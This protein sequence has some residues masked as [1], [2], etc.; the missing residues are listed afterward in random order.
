[1]IL[2][3]HPTGNAN[4]RH[5][6]LGLFRAGLT[7]EFWTC[8]HYRAPALLERLLPARVAGQLRRRAW[9]PEL[10]DAIRT[11][12]FREL[13]RHVAPRLGLAGLTAHET[14]VFSVDA[15]YRA[16]DRAVARR[17]GRGG[18]RAVY[19]YEDGA[20]S[21]FME[22]RRRGL[23]TLYDL[24]IGHWRAARALLLEEA[25]REPEWAATL[26]GN[27]D[28]AAKTE[29]K[30]AEL[31]LADVV[32]VA[33]SYTRRTLD[34]AADFRGAVLVVPYGAPALASVPSSLPLPPAKTLRVL[35]VGS[36]GQRKGLSYLFA[37]CRR[38]RSAVT[39]TVIGR[40]PAEPCAALD[41]ELRSVRWIPSCPH[42]QVLA[43]MAAHDVFVFPSLFEGFGLVLLEALA[44][45]LPVITTPHTAGPDLIRDGV[46]GFIVPIRDSSAIA[47]R[48][49]LLH[50]EPERRAGM[51]RSARLRAREYSWENYEQTLASC[52]ARALA[53]T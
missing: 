19:A 1:M 17:L 45:G 27:R 35:F 15:V 47:E 20:R 28:S 7:A 43:E 39:L 14:G 52:V 25:A 44:A 18:F 29:R 31:A 40:K 41:R 12:P 51:S 3:S 22:A 46:E 48:L 9:P 8:L 32:F 37:A 6:A 23:L 42:P 5:A 4:A 26:T 36:L 21:S 33:S 10:S 2:F 13:M 38:V 24:P 53:A 11:R 50:R 16:L 34:E 30:D 49:E